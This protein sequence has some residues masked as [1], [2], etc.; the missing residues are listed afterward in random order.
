VGNS[1][2]KVNLKELKFVLEMVAQNIF[3]DFSSGF[4]QYKK[5]VRDNIRKHWSSNDK[6]DYPQN[7]VSFGLSSIQFPRERVRQICSAKLSKAVINW[8]QNDNPGS[9]SM[10]DIIQN[11]ILVDLK[12]SESSSQSQLLDSLS[13][14]VSQKTLIREVAD[15]IAYLRKRRDDLNIPFENLQKFISSEQAKFDIH[16]QDEDTDPRR[17]SD[18]F[19]S[20][21]ANLNYLKEQKRQELRQ[22]VYTLL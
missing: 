14:G 11:Q 7:F 16:F 1:N 18:Y 12:L 15:W 8:W 19:K 21:W 10:R 4:S 2:D 13:T 20:M 9:S 22:L 5:L 17:W 6:L 3:L